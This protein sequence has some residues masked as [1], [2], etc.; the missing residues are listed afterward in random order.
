M[1][2]A[3]KA[4]EQSAAN[5][6]AGMMDLFG[7]VVPTSNDVEDVYSDFHRVRSWNIKERLQAEKE[8]L[9]LYLTGHPIDEYDSELNHLVS[10]RIADLKPEKSNQT[11]AGLVVAQ[12]VMKTK[13]GDSMAFVTLDDRTGRIEVAIFSDA[14]TQARD[15]LL[16]DG[17]LVING[18]V[19]YDDYNGMLKMRADTISLLADVRQQKARELHLTVESGALPAQFIQDLSGLLEPYR[20]GSCPLVIDYQRSDARAQLRLGNDWLVRPEDELLQRLRDQYGADKV[21]LLY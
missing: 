14:Y 7:D 2:E 17:L 6:S 9:G 5:S 16:K 4:A 8:T 1:N 13:R 21:K 12:R 19:S 3:V 10:S 18:Q 15:L 11:V 20:E